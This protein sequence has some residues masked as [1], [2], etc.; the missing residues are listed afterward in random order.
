M[1]VKWSAAA[2][3]AIKQ[4]VELSCCSNGSLYSI[5]VKLGLIFPGDIK[6]ESFHYHVNK[7]GWREQV[8][9]H[10]KNAGL[11]GRGTP[12]LV[13]CRLFSSARLQFSVRLIPVA[14]V[15]Q[16]LKVAKHGVE[17]LQVNAGAAE[18]GVLGVVQELCSG[19]LQAELL[20][21]GAASAA[22]IYGM[23]LD[24]K[25]LVNFVAKAIKIPKLKCAAIHFPAIKFGPISG[26]PKAGKAVINGWLG[27][28]QGEGT[29]LAV[30]AEFE[31]FAE[32]VIKKG[33]FG[34][35]GG[36]KITPDLAHFKM[37][38]PSQQDS[39]WLDLRKAGTQGWSVA[40]FNTELRDR[41]NRYN[42]AVNL[43]ADDLGPV[44]KLWIARLCYHKAD[45][46]DEGQQKGLLEEMLH[47]IYYKQNKLDA[48][49]ESLQEVGI[50]HL[51]AN[52]YPTTKGLSPVRKKVTSTQ[53]PA[54]VDAE[55]AWKK[56]LKDREARRLAAEVATS[57]N[58]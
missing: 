40:T 47:S 25:V 11:E 58:E 13:G 15:A 41:I 29:Q 38:F 31:Q 6:K 43:D 28:L 48:T 34:R 17:E 26:K 10:Y 51:Q 5:G 32:K 24:E 33:R 2:D 37:D 36:G 23:S 22:D 30:A 3:A 27:K 18:F 56:V 52:V 9:S 20:L 44:L 57:G 12:D 39:A 1:S 54:T 19:L 14:F 21:T 55:R 4:L 35:S 16:E 45:Q 42:T 50:R 53:K 49:I 7:Q 46:D 8:A